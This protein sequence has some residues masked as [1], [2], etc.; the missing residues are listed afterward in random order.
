M[1]GDGVNDPDKVA[2]MGNFNVTN[3]SPR[4][5]W[6]TVG[7]WMP[8]PAT[9]RR[10][11]RPHPLVENKPAIAMVRQKGRKGDAAHYFERSNELRPNPVRHDDCCVRSVAMWVRQ[12]R[13]SV[14]EGH[15]GRWGKR[16][17]FRAALRAAAAGADAV[18]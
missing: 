11:A 14:G 18:A 12:G 2:L 7:E 9:G 10:A 17:M 15:G 8:R 6:V 16:S 5:S 13:G 1:V 3:A 4:E